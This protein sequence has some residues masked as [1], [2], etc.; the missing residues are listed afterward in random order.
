MTAALLS[1]IERDVLAG[2]A[3]GE[4]AE[5]T[6]TRLHRALATVKH[7]RR[8]VL[9]KLGARNAAHAVAIAYD[10]G[11]LGERKP[12]T[13][14]DRQLVAFQARTGDI[15]KR[16]GV[17]RSEVRRVALGRASTQFEHPI[18]EASALTSVEASWLLD[19]LRDVVAGDE[20]L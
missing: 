6:A 18:S 14:N 19:L 7:H 9:S 8:H 20:E 2:V 17:E 16:Q 5:E 12:E 10:H 11:V 15:A 13:I 3:T 1:S 4:T